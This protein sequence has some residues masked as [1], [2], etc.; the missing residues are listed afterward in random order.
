MKFI[1]I[2]CGGWQSGSY[3]SE[4][5]QADNYEEQ[6]FYFHQLP[7][8]SVS[9]RCLSVVF[10]VSS[11]S[12]VYFSSLTHVYPF[13]LGSVLATVIGVRHATPLLKRLNRSLDL[14]QTFASLWVWSR[15]LALIDFSLLK[16]NFNLFAYLTW[17]LVSKFSCASDDCCSTTVT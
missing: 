12:T 6:S 13:F 11:Y 17:L 1:I 16:F 9:F 7:L 5:N 10:I 2:S 3:L 14:K 4:Q 15:S 8:S